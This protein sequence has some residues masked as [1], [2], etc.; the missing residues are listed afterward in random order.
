LSIRLILLPARR[1]PCEVSQHRDQ[2][3][4]RRRGGK[5]LFDLNPAGAMMAVPI[6]V[7]GSTLE[8]AAPVAPCPARWGIYRGPAVQRRPRRAV[9]HQPGTGQRAG[10]DHA[11]DDWNPAAKK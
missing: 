9:S 7:T 4:W 10:A 8:P 1:R 6:T 5:Q 11:A 2:P 3:R